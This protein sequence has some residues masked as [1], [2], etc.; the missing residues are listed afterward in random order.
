MQSEDSKVVQAFADLINAQILQGKELSNEDYADFY[1]I[2]MHN[3]SIEHPEWA[4][5][6]ISATSHRELKRSKQPVKVS[7]HLQKRY[8]RAFRTLERALAAAEATNLALIGAFVDSDLARK[9]DMLFDTN[10]LG[11]KTIMVLLLIG[12]HAR[13]TRTATE[14]ALLLKSGYP[15][16]AGAR[17][18]TIYELAVKAIV[19]MNDQSPRR[20]ELAERYYLSGIFEAARL[21]PTVLDDALAIRL[22]TEARRRWGNKIFEGDNNWALPAFTKTKKGRV[23]FRDLEDLVGAE[24]MRHLYQ[25]GNMSVHA[26]ALQIVQAGNFSRK[27]LYSCSSEVDI[28][29]TGRL[30]QACA[31]Y[32]D[33]ATVEIVRRLS[34]HTEHLDIPLMAIEFFNQISLAQRLFHEVYSSFDE[35]AQGQPSDSHPG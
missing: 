23:T 6:S 29:S 2:L 26:G 19:I 10:E 31:F 3:A 17:S 8:A 4:R 28:I 5:A 14:V 13:I 12:I 11:G 18:R 32:L 9:P 25:E 16:G 34:F 33:V 30:G 7:R 27:Y 15:E 35:P 24:G 1:H 20:C 22:L 21:D